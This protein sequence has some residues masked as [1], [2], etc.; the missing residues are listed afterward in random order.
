[1]KRKLLFAM[2][3]I[4]GALGL[5]AQ[6]WTSAEVA[7][8]EFYLY[9]VGRAEFFTKGNGWGTQAS[10]TTSGIPTDGIK[11]TLSDVDGKWFICTGV[12]NAAY[13]LEHLIG[14][15][16]Y[17]DQS[18]N[19]KSTWTFTQVGT[20]NGPVYNIV[21]ADN[22]GGG[23]NAVLTALDGTVVGPGNDGT[24]DDA[25]W[26]LLDA[27][28]LT[29]PVRYGEIKVAALAVI[30]ALDTTKPDEAL[31]GSKTVADLQGAIA[32]LRAA[33][34]TAL[35]GESIPADP[36]YIDVTAVLIDNAGVHTNTDYWTIA[37]LSE[38]GG[39]AG[40]CNYGECEF[41]QRNF[42]F[43]QTLALDKGTWE[44]GVTGFHRAGNHSTY[45]YAGEDKIL[46]PGVSGSVVNDMAGAKDYFDAG[47]GK[48][49]LKF[50]LEDGD[51]KTIEIGIENKDTETDK[52]TIFRNFTLKYYGSAVDYTTYKNRWGTR[53]SAMHRTRKAKRL[54]IHAR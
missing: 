18:R 49:A 3:S 14:G 44:F 54:T 15:T 52:W 27:R 12:N 13:G 48:V 29:L 53:P 17:T 23:A 32:S 45:F 38:T 11:V 34:I 40:V 7:A 26:K 24:K 41:Y 46:I 20:D 39:N 6:M 33:F 37:N 9:N 31:D 16:C 43:Y 1:M 36:G 5:R 47:N 51:E 22:H 19:K 8:G 25:K 21:S 2:L 42:K 50:V 4:I 10:V 30:P 28:M 35:P